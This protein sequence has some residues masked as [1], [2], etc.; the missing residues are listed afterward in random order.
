MRAVQRS[1]A[2]EAPTGRELLLHAAARAAPV[3][4]EEPRVLS[5]AQDREHVTRWLHRHPRDF[6]ILNVD[7]GEPA[8]ADINLCVDTIDD[9]GR[10]ERFDD[11]ALRARYA[12]LPAPVGRLV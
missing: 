7:S 4:P 12:S 8:L 1:L 10:L 6:R 3:H 9:L 5:R 11:E 2:V